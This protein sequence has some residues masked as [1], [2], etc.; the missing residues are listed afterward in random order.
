VRLAKRLGTHHT[1]EVR[2]NVVDKVLLVTAV[3]SLVAAERF[4]RVSSSHGRRKTGSDATKKVV[5]HDLT[6]LVNF[7]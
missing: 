7:F 6:A 1:R 3:R 4:C 5:H 2:F